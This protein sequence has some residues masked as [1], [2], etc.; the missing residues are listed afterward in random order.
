MPKKYFSLLFTVLLIRIAPQQDQSSIE[1]QPTPDPM[2]KVQKAM[3]GF[4]VTWRETI[5][6]SRRGTA[7]SLQLL[8]VRWDFTGP[9]LPRS[10]KFRFFHEL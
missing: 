9:G 3:V 7:P 8:T 6:S 4:G 1:W 10:Q 2:A 5:P